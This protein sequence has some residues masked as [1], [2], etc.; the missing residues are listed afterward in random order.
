MDVDSVK[1]FKKARRRHKKYSALLNTKADNDNQA[2]Y[3]AKQTNH[4]LRPRSRSSVWKRQPRPD[5]T[6]EMSEATE[7][8]LELRKELNIP[9]GDSESE[10][11]EAASPSKVARLTQEN[12]VDTPENSQQRQTIGP[13]QNGLGQKNNADPQKSQTNGP[14]QDG[15][16]NVNDPS[17]TASQETGDASQR[18]SGSGNSTPH[19]SCN[20][21][22]VPQVQPYTKKLPF[23]PPN[24]TNLRALKTLL[25]D[26]EK[27]FDK[28]SNDFKVQEL[29]NEFYEKQKI[30]ATPFVKTLLSVFNP[31]YAGIRKRA[32][33]K[34]NNDLEKN[35]FVECI[36]DVKKSR[37]FNQLKAR[38]QAIFTW[39]A[40]ISTIKPPKELEVPSGSVNSTSGQT[41]AHKDSEK[42]NMEDEAFQRE[43]NLSSYSS[44]DSDSDME[45]NRKRKKKRKRRLK[46]VNDLTTD[47]ND[48][49][50]NVNELVRS[51]HKPTK[52]VCK[53][54]RNVVQLV[55]KDLENMMDVELT[56]K[57]ELE[58]IVMNIIT[59]HL[60]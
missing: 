35:S 47:V 57:E 59:K 39:P 20:S 12:N 1:A 28:A 26:K 45:S 4:A 43:V 31:D 25:L 40:L 2:D 46:D 34:L 29:R 50:T 56:E 17:N 36:E 42:E 27:L 38:F 15:S 37:E 51:D 5:A 48:M 3:S 52:K 9:P 49:T 19:G 13:I 32:R 11:E 22:S 53:V 33:R 6:V 10:D 41:E 7:T 55:Y 58:I 54:K 30:N 18:S 23:I 16:D 24:N 14:G 44:T 8:M 60:R 21:V